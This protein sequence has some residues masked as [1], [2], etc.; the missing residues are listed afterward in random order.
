MATFVDVAG[1]EYPSSYGDKN[2]LPME[3]KSL[4]PIFQGKKRE[5]HEGLYWQTYQGGHRAVR[6]G[7]WKMVT[8]SA[9]EPWELYDLDI[10]K[11][12]L[13]DLAMQNPDVVRELSGMWESWAVR[14]G[15]PL[16]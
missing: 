6:K 3:G 12:E 16:N 7:K 13:H 11:T 2:I 10:D 8:P 5:G 9:E 14:C 4:L 1:A 15:I